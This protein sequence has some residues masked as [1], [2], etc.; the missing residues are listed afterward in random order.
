MNFF[1]DVDLV[2][3]H[4][5]GRAPRVDRKG[6]RHVFSPVASV[7]G[8]RRPPRETDGAWASISTVACGERDRY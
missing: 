2:V 3:H 7:D 8:S 5:Q 4:Q 1:Q 6:A